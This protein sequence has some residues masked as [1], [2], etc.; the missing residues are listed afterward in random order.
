MVTLNKT[1]S[2]KKLRHETFTCDFREIVDLG[3]GDGAND[4]NQFLM[5]L[6]QAEMDDILTEVIQQ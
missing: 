3:Y 5:G 1:K 4:Y 6:W 2:D